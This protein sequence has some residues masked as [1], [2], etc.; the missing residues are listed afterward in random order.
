MLVGDNGWAK[1][2]GCS[3]GVKAGGEGNDRFEANGRG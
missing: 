3:P 2:Y 1:P